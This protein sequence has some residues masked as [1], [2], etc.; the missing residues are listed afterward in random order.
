MRKTR[1]A[2]GGDDRRAGI[3]VR[4][5]KWDGEGESLGVQRQEKDCRAEAERRGWDVVDVYQDD[6]KSAFSGKK[7]DQYVRLCGD[8]KA[9][10]IDAVIVWHNDR[11]HRQ[12]RELEDFIDLIEATGATIV[13]VAGG[14]YDLS[15]S[16]GRFRARIEGGVARKESE[17]K[18]RRLRR[19][20]MELAD[21]GLPNGGRRPTG[22][23]RVGLKKDPAAGGADTRRLVV[24]PVEGPIVER[25]IN[26]VAGERTLTGIAD[27]LNAEG[28]VT[29]TGGP[30]T[31][32]AVRSVALN[33]L[34][35]GLRFHKGE[36]VGAGTWPTIVDEA[37]WR[38][39]VALLK[40][41]DRP[42]RRSAR[43][44]LLV[45]GIAVCGK[46]LAAGKVSPLR[47]KQH[48]SKVRAA[49][50]GTVMVPTY[51]CPPT[52]K[53]GCGGLSARADAVEQLVQEAVIERVES[54]AFARV[55]RSHDGGDRK[56]AAEVN[57]IRAELDDLEAAKLNG[58][59][60]LRE[61]LK[62]RDAATERL[63]GAQ[64]RMEGDTRASAVGRFAGQAGALRAWWDNP[65]TTLDQKQAVLRAVVERVVVEP[66]SKAS[67]NRFDQSRVKVQMF[68]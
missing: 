24:D 36:E 28:A 32:W 9:G 39:A 35:A 6:D 31:I 42:Q 13:S 27:E 60:S 68:V 50:G 38:R 55:L 5:S 22:Y 20:H 58:A 66:V 61:Y 7:R 21:L 2:K 54:K 14:D 15:T 25:I 26:A 48:H 34:Y 45:G 64:G 53:G 44:Y 65:A 23:Q 57:G 40:A 37:T 43:R 47:S 56:A 8:L 62:F 29:S 52:T 59:L 17:D 49:R 46:C 67:G 41:P 16:D 30:W 11:L 1:A 12:P 18:S 3:Y 51:V 4:I 33:G 63:V 19:K 10:V